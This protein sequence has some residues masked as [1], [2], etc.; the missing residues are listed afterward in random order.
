MCRIGDDMKRL[1]DL[2]NPRP[3]P[4]YF[5]LKPRSPCTNGSNTL[6]LR[7]SGMPGPVSST[8]NWKMR[9]FALAGGGVGD[10][11][12]T[13]ILGVDFGSAPF[14]NN[15]VPWIGLDAELEGFL[16]T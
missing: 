1:R 4:P 9:I 10:L 3:V 5:L 6:S 7:C 16:E 11:S 8:S 12:R 15:A 2:T 14:K 13:W